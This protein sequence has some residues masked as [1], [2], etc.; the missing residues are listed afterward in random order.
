MSK[1]AEEFDAVVIGAGFSGIYM[2]HKLREQGL[3]T[4]VLEAGEGVGGAWY[5]NRYPGARCDSESYF[6]CFS[7][8]PEILQEWTWSEKFPAQAEIEEYLNFVTD[9]L[10]LRKDMQFNARVKSA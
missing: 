1:I 6:Y 8:S 4:R 5:W 2:L 7:F 9:R 10:D 3:K